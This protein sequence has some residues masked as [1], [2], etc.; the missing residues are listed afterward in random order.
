MGGLLFPLPHAI[1]S[2]VT[3]LDERPRWFGLFGTINGIAMV[4]GLFLGG[5]IVDN[6]GPFSLF[7]LTSA[8][9]A[10]ALFLLFLFYPNQPKKSDVSI[11][12]GGIA[13]LSVTL[14]CI[15]GWCSLGGSLFP[16]TSP[17]GLVALAVGS[18]SLFL[19]IMHERHTP[20]PL[21][22]PKLFRNRSYIVSFSVQLLIPPMVYLCSSMLTL[23]GQSVWVCRRPLAARWRC[24]KTCCSVFCRCFLAL[25]WPKTGADSVS[26]FL[27]AVPLSVWGVWPPL[28]GQPQLP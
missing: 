22:T 20:A 21:L 28:H 2:D 24:P 5:L 6:F 10:A 14:I 17:F 12:W 7:P 8:I 1:L 11:D 9:G 4:I 15:M 18:I 3:T 27:S 25:F 23:Y 13:I 19:L 16:R 26:P